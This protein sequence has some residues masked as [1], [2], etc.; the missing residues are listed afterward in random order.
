MRYSA[1]PK[2]GV[3]LDQINGVHIHLA[4]YTFSVRHPT[5][6]TDAEI[7]NI[8]QIH[9]VTMTDVT[10]IDFCTNKQG[11]IVDK[12]G[13]NYEGTLEIL[14]RKDLSAYVTLVESHLYHTN[15]LNGGINRWNM[16][17]YRTQI[18]NKGRLWTN[19][20][21]S[22]SDKV[23]THSGFCRIEFS[24]TDT[25]GESIQANTLFS[26]TLFKINPCMI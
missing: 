24:T 15:G 7:Q 11:K 8:I 6:F 16:N 2:S 4:T 10:S 13:M 5:G 19:D 20:C 3:S 25:M 14:T 18:D 26:F 23:S 17:T 21:V 12:Y 1:G 9:A 22:G